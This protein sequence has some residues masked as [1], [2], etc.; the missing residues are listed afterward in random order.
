MT[1]TTNDFEL[2][3]LKCAEVAR[4][5]EAGEGTPLAIAY[6]ALGLGE[7]GEVQGK[8]KK[9]LR[10]D[11]FIVTDEKR[12]AIALELGDVL[13]YVARMADELGYSLQQIADKNIEKLFD[14]AERGV[15]GGSGDYR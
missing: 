2:Y 12:E 4:Y 6:V 14:R 5:P 3:Q 7:A 8:V 1:K 15:L 11:D 9:I 10:D 13:W